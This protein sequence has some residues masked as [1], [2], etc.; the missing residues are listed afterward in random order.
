MKKIVFTILFILLTSCPIL[1]NAK[2][3]NKPNENFANLVFFAYYD[4]TN[5]EIQEDLKYYENN[6]DMLIDLYNG[7]TKRSFTNYLKEVSYGK[8]NAKIIFPQLENGI[9]KPIK[10]NIN[11]K[12]SYERNN[13]T[14]LIDQIVATYPSISNQIVDYNNDGF[15]DNLTI[16]IKSR[17]GYTA[18]NQ[19]TFTSHKADYPGTKNYLNKLIGTYNI[20]STASIENNKSGVIAH[21]FLHSLGYPDL[22][23]NGSADDYPVHVW[24]IMASANQGMSYPLAYLRKAI[25]NWV[26]IE[27]VTESKTLRLDLQSNKDGNQAYILKSPLNDYEYFVV[28]YR[29]KDLS[30]DQL[31]RHIGGSG[32]IVYRV[33][34]T[35]DGYSNHY[36]ETGVY[37]FRPQSGFETEQQKVYNAHLSVESGRTSIGSSNMNLGLKDGALTFSDGSNS[38]IVIK[39]VSSTD[40]PYMTLDVEIPKAENFDLWKNKNFPDLI[41]GNAH[42]N[43]TLANYNNTL[44]AFSYANNKVYAQSLENNKWVTKGSYSNIKTETFTTIKVVESN[45]ELYLI[46]NNTNAI[47]VY[48]WNTSNHT[49]TLFSSYQETLNEFDVSVIN[50]KIYIAGSTSNNA[51]LYV[52]NNN[53]IS[54]LGNYHS[55]INGIPRIGE[56]NNKVYVSIKSMQG[57]LLLYQY[58]ANK[59]TPINTGINTNNYDLKSLDNKLYIVLGTDYN[60]NNISLKKYDGNNWET[61][62]SSLKLSFPNMV[63]S[64]GNLYI[65]GTDN[66]N[67]Y[68]YSYHENT[69]K[70]TME[71]T[72]VDTGSPFYDTS[73]VALNNSIYVGIKKS[74]DTLLVKAKETVNSL[75]SLNITPPNKITYEIGEKLDKTGLKVIANYTNGQKEINNYTITNF[76]TDKIGTYNATITYEGFSNTF[77][78]HVIKKNDDT[79]KDNLAKI[80]NGKYVIRSALDDNKVLDIQGGSKTS[81]TNV[82]LYDYNASDAQVWNITYLKDGYYTISSQINHELVLDVSYGAKEN[83]TNVQVYSNNN[84]IAQQWLIKET[85]DGYYYL[86]SKCNNLNLDIVAA[87]TM[88]GTNI[89]MYQGNGTRAQKFK[90]DKLDRTIEDGNYVIRSALDNNKVLDVEYGSKTSGTN[91]QLYDYNGSNAQIWNITYVKDGYYKI[92]SQLD[93]NL[94]IDVSG[95]SKNNGANVQ[96]YSNNNSKAQQW[97]IKEAE[98]GYYYLISRCNVLNLDITS[99]QTKNGTNIQMYKGNFSKAQKFKL[100]KN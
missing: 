22:Y 31:D 29:K 76:N 73:L 59:F 96:V 19:S 37:V 74:D 77:T 5:D 25:T 61:I 26:D 63:I 38:G 82:Q 45:H 55:G 30:I 48:K 58:D 66:N 81:G 4:G 97:F 2:A 13:D 57:D 75:I 67:L 10:L 34:T 15:I 50:N 32:I 20:I 51:I 87:Q 54:K 65:L 6:N 33:D 41:G 21:E 71:G 12:D 44:Y 27:T 92:S 47:N 35:V 68:T 18:A 88:N 9:I 84:S 56:I 89:Q 42:K 28:E 62:S 90:L 86:I 69:K 17:S 94:V 16:I 99:A 39:N 40:G 8:F 52:L 60:N 100:D 98:N 85:G 3:S 95:G 1:V 23:R 80:E 70:F 72:I 46:A 83:G 11:I 78:Y 43:I 49:W 53:T 91:V 7:N 93:N 36:G 64:Q 14:I 24:D 79:D